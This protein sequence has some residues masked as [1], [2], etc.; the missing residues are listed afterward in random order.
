MKRKTLLT[1]LCILALLWGSA[2]A[3]A[4]V[5][6]SLDRTELALG[7][8]VA[9]TIETDQAAV[10]DLSPLAADFGLSGQSS[11]RRM[12]LGSGGVSASTT[13]VVNLTPRRA[14]VLPIPS[15]QVGSQRTA[16][17]SVT[18]T[19]LPPLAAS[20]GDARAF[21]ETEVDDPSPYVQQ[22]VGVTVRLFYAVPL[23][24]GELDLDTPDGASLQQVGQDVQSSRD[25]GG[26]RYNVVERRFL[27]VPERSGALTIPGARFVGRG[28]GGWMD[29]FFGGNSRELR[30]TGAPRRLEVQAQP[31]DAPQP[32]LPLRGL[33][34]RYVAAPQELRAGEAASLVIEATA[35][36]A[37][38]AQLPELPTPSMAGAQ[39]F[40]EPAQ[41]DETFSG[42][43]PQVRVTRR[44]SIVPNAQGRLV[45]PGIKLG[46]WDV[47]AAA[48]RVA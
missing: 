29:D 18:V 24:S 33:T 46:W 15:L 37:I 13:H 41:Y 2:S 14:G 36:G 26:R 21:L 48:P 11:R 47:G 5:R 1:C 4:A 34:L 27:L 42:G 16:P 22:S 12:Q 43:S 30:A 39:V 31:A 23:A 9:L 32:W 35:R 45:V 10:P 40:A 28:A 19:E 8:S 25:V 20:R 3:Y 6:A 38:Q 44:Y 17:L 7:E